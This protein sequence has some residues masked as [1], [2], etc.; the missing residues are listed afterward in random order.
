PEKP[1]SYRTE[2]TLRYF[3]CAERT[4]A[5]MRFEWRNADDKPALTNLPALLT[6]RPVTAGTRDEQ[7]LEAA[8]NYAGDLASPEAA[9]LQL[10][11]ATARLV[12]PAN[13]DEYYPRGSIRRREQGSP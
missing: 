11:E 5:V 10:P 1:V 3:N 6:F 2:V 9:G 7:M 13:P 8:C 12:R 4:S